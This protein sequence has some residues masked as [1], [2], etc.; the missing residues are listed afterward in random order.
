MLVLVNKYNKKMCEK[1]GKK[2]QVSQ[3]ILIGVVFLISV[4]VVTYIKETNLLFRPSLVVPA[5]VQPVANF[6]EECI[7]VVY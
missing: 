4:F 1:R 6:I 2:A 3:F 7:V 5:N